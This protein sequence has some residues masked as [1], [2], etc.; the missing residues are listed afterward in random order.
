MALVG[1]VEIKFGLLADG[2]RESKAR[3]DNQRVVGVARD[4]I[5]LGQLR[6]HFRLVGIGP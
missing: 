4:R 3:R 1:R 2:A 5:G 6:R